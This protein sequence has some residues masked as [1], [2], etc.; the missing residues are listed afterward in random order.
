LSFSNHATRIDHGGPNREESVELL[1]HSVTCLSTL[2]EEK[3]AIQNSANSEDVDR[4][5]YQINYFSF[6]VIHS[7]TQS[8]SFCIIS[9]QK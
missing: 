2:L 3:R 1:H 6:S 5:I 7:H 9:D 8:S 4:F